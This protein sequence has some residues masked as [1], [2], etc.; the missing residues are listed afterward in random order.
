M[1]GKLTVSTIVP[2]HSAGGFVI[3]GPDSEDIPE[4]HARMIGAHAWEGGVHPYSDDA[5]G[6]GQSDRPDGQEPAR[7]GKG[8]GRDAWVAFAGE[9]G[10][11]DLA[12]G[13]SRDEIVQALIDAGLIDA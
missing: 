2:D 4:E 6:D 1:G 9:K 13:K 3:Y 7:S 8:S 5:D 11:A 10:H 12:D